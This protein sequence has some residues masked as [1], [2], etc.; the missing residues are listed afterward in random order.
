MEFIEELNST[1]AIQRIP[2]SDY[3]TFQEDRFE[4]R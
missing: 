4:S 3:A 1:K 2:D